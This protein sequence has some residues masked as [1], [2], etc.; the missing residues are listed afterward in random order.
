MSCPPKSFTGIRK[1]RVV[2]R[3]QA[4]F[5]NSGV[6]TP[7]PIAL[8][9]TYGQLSSTGTGTTTTITQEVEVEVNNELQPVSSSLQSLPVGTNPFTVADYRQMYANI[10]SH[11][12]ETNAGSLAGSSFTAPFTGELKSFTVYSAEDF[13]CTVRVECRNVTTGTDTELFVDVNKESAAG[14]TR[15]G[16]VTEAQMPA[17]SRMAFTL[18]DTLAFALFV[19][20]AGIEAA[21]TTVKLTYTAI[22]EDASTDTTQAAATVFPRSYFLDHK[23][24]ELTS[25]A[26]QTAPNR[27]Q[28]LQDTVSAAGALMQGLTPF[29]TVR[30]PFAGCLRAVSVEAEINSSSSV[31]YVEC[32]RVR[33]ATLGGSANDAATDEGVFDADTGDTTACTLTVACDTRVVNHDATDIYA[34]ESTTSD[35]GVRF[36]PFEEGDLLSFAYQR[37]D[38]TTAVRI[39][40]RVELTAWTTQAPPAASATDPVV[41]KVSTDAITLIN[42][43]DTDA[44]YAQAAFGNIDSTATPG[45]DM[46]AQDPETSFRAPFSGVVYAIAAECNQTTDETLLIKMRKVVSSSTTATTIGTKVSMTLSRQPVASGPKVGFVSQSQDSWSGTDGA[47]LGVSFFPFDEGDQLS[48][49]LCTTSGGAEFRVHLYLTSFTGGATV[50]ADLKSMLTLGAGPFSFSPGTAE[51]GTSRYQVLDRQVEAS[52]STAITGAATSYSTI[53]HVPYDCRLSSIEVMTDQSEGTTWHIDIRKAPLDTWPTTWAAQTADKFVVKA[54]ADAMGGSN[55]SGYARI[56]DLSSSAVTFAAHDVIAI[57]VGLDPAGIETGTA[58][59]VAASFRVNLQSYAT[60]TLGSSPATPM[61]MV[62]ESMHA[63][64]VLQATAATTSASCELMYGDINS[65]ASATVSGGGE[66]FA[67]FVAPF[68]GCVHTMKHLHWDSLSTTAN[69]KPEVRVV[70]SLYPGK[71]TGYTVPMDTPHTALTTN[72]SVDSYLDTLDQSDDRLGRRCTFR[73]GD[74]VGMALHAGTNN[75]AKLLQGGLVISNDRFADFDLTGG[76]SPT[77][78]VMTSKYNKSVFFLTASAT[79][80]YQEYDTVVNKA[81]PQGTAID[82]ATN[83]FRHFWTNEFTG[84]LWAI[85]VLVYDFAGAGVTFNLDYKNSTTVVNS[86]ITCTAYAGG[87]QAAGGLQTLADANIASFTFSKDEI[88]S[89]GFNCSTGH[90]M[91]WRAW[92]VNDNSG[93][94]TISDNRSVLFIESFKRTFTVISGALS[95]SD[96]EQ[97]L[98]DEGFAMAEINSTV[99]QSYKTAIHAPCTGYVSAVWVQTT[100]TADFIASVQV[101]KLSGATASSVDVL[102]PVKRV[103]G[104]PTAGMGLYEFTSAE[105][106]FTRGDLLAM[107]FAVSDSTLSPAGA[108]TIDYALRL[109]FVATA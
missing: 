103:Y 105:A 14:G 95:D 43:T 85:S 50:P 39:R 47:A 69:I 61:V 74:L 80:Y 101:R 71:S 109:E 53:F 55:M 84:Q 83:S 27:V 72:F 45:N 79:N 108:A 26:T 17:G 31:F 4:L 29:T 75:G 41:Y 33:V 62:V 34:G 8:Y 104:T 30:A 92:F 64:N 15:S 90:N 76:A 19:D 63:V 81:V 98:D 96:H 16:S 20:P 40:P 5:N 38:A 88:C 11:P 49:S 82:D 12:S 100:S 1:A 2:G 68:D 60:Q 18:G 89:I 65:A 57:A 106:T 73:K 56:A 46:Q 32:R 52:L 67:C 93:T 42:Q 94:P 24:F 91:R 6:P 59:T 54:D 78:L 10:L 77:N 58:A 37:K 13:A 9:K 86:S 87:T 35:F 107:A 25:S 99:T 23:S 28:A 97:V 22:L 21:N 44:D 70:R 3:P 48:M 102:I 7:R 36:F 66:Y 51:P